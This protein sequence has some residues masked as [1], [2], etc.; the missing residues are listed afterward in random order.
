M[1][2]LLKPLSWNRHLAHVRANIDWLW[3]GLLARRNLTL[4]TGGW[5]SGKTTLVSLLLDR[6]NARETTT[7]SPE[8]HHLE[9]PTIRQ[10]SEKGSCP[11]SPAAGERAGVRG[12]REPEQEA[13]TP[14]KRPNRH[15]ARR[16]D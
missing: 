16:R 6:R 14:R 3:P 15:L 4:L 2:P 8:D 9:T 5:K 1:S 13:P 12:R 7:R 11:L 10:R